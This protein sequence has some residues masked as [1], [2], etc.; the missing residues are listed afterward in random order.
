M[1]SVKSRLL[2]P[3]TYSGIGIDHPTGITTGPD[4]ALWFTN[5]E[6]NG[7]IGRITTAGVVTNYTGT[8]TDYPDSITTESDGAMW[9]TNVNGVIGR[10]TAAGVVSEYPGRAWITRSP[11]PPVRTG[12][13]VHQLLGGPSD[14][15][16]NGRF[17]TLGAVTRFTGGLWIGGTSRPGPTV[18]FGIS[19]K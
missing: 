16:S 14:L 7:S 6:P 8:G 13:E 10:I 18:L 12:F 1:A 9:F 3:S 5:D 19:A 11:S 2:E 17:T 15:G 4:G